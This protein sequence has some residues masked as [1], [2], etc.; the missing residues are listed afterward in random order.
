MVSALK[1]KS[2]L[3]ISY[4]LNTIRVYF[5]GKLFFISDVSVDEIK[6]NELNCSRCLTYIMRKIKNANNID[7]KMYYNKIEMD[8]EKQDHIKFMET[9]QNGYYDSNNEIKKLILH[10]LLILQ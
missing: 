2:F 8:C 7:M 5:I 6:F 9:E 10:N 3:Q 4:N 1:D